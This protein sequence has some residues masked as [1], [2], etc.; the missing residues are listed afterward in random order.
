MNERTKERGRVLRKQPSG[1]PRLAH[2]DAPPAAT[3]LA[4]AVWPN[5][6]SQVLRLERP[7]WAARTGAS[8]E[9]AGPVSAAPPQTRSLGTLP[10]LH[11]GRVWAAGDALRGIIK[12]HGRGDQE[13]L[14]PHTE[15]RIRKR[16]GSIRAAPGSRRKGG[17][18]TDGG[19]GRARGTDALGHMDSWWGLPAPPGSSRAGRV[20]L[21]LPNSP[22]S[23]REAG[24]YYLP[25]SGTTR[26][27]SHRAGAGLWGGDP[28]PHSQL[29]KRRGGQW[30]QPRLPARV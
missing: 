9:I 11:P 13:K 29:Q 24:G 1:G 18:R 20:R 16:A 6:G 5:P 4:S 10:N 30:E 22:A 19:R 2:E 8:A 12:E 14:R 23:G 17:A 25:P 26:R 28:R 27:P 21:G 7:F 3:A 15:W